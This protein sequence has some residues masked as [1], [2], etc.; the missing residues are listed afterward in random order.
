LTRCSRK[1]KERKRDE[2]ETEKEGEKECQRE[3]ER[4]TEG[5]RKI[6]KGRNR[7]G[8]TSEMRRRG[9]ARQQSSPDQ[10]SGAPQSV[11][12]PS[13][14]LSVCHAKIFA[15]LDSSLLSSVL[16]LSCLTVGPLLSNIQPRLSLS[17]TLLPSPLHLVTGLPPPLYPSL[18]SSSPFL[19]PPVPLSILS[20][21]APALLIDIEDRYEDPGP[22]IPLLLPQCST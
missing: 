5:E 21:T 13:L 2:R 20:P 1:C 14:F 17:F 10:F 18:P 4:E 16:L 12:R 11:L 6:K 7:N 3:E 8:K 22:C 19:L 9:T 15:P